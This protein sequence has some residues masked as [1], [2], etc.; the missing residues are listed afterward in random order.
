MR[1][2]DGARTSRER[3]L[4]EKKAK[5]RRKGAVIG[6]FVLLGVAFAA[7][8]GVSFAAGEAIK[9]SHVN[10]EGVMTGLDGSAVK[11]EEVR[12]YATL[13]DLPKIETN[14]L[15][16]L[17]QL[18]VNLAGDGAGAWP[19][20]A[21]ATFKVTSAIKPSDDELYLF[22]ASGAVAHIDAAN[23][24][25][26]VTLADGATFSVVEDEAAAS[27][28]RELQAGG[29]WRDEPPAA[30]GRGRDEGA[31]PP[32]RILQRF[33]DERELH[34]HAG[35]R[36]LTPMCDIAWSVSSGSKYSKQN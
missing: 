24:T 22:L 3:V 27:L 31:P 28:R 12:S 29:G 25:A 21:Q 36:V 4:K 6:L 32:S 35:R 5:K 10:A 26:R 34:V 14:I 18:T 9:E 2:D 33:D 19:A 8:F 17:D 30:P 20:V 23:T 7:I 15:A 1:A 16:F 11:T 13:Y